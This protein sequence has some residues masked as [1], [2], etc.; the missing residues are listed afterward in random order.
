MMDICGEQSLVGAA[1]PSGNGGKGGEHA[2]MD[3]SS[4]VMQ[5]QLP[6]MRKL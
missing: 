1:L 5:E 3:V 2:Y 4:R 6:R